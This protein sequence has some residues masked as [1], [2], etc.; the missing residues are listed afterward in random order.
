MTDPTR[1]RAADD[2]LV[3]VHPPEPGPSARLTSD[4]ATP[5]RGP[6]RQT[7][8]F[9]R[10]NKSALVGLVLIILVLLFSFLGPALY[11]TDQIHA[12]L[13]ATNLPPSSHHL[14]GTD[15]LGYDVLGRIMLGGQSSIEIGLAVALI[16]TTIGAIWGSLAA[17][18]GGIVDTLMMRV[19]DVLLA[20]PALFIVI[21]LATALHPNIWTLIGVISFISW[22][23]PARLIRGESLSIR[24]QA[25]VEAARR[26]GARQPWIL[27]RHIVPNAV[28]IIVVNATFQVADAVLLLAYLSFLG[29]G[30]PPPAAS[31][32]GILAEGLN[33][34]FNGYWWEIYPAGIIIVITVIAFNLL[35]DALRD[36]VDGRLRGR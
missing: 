17:L 28:G 12:N 6:L 16:A 7:G 20:V 30:L 22:L 3:I 31:W 19:V 9:L 15:D 13:T 18:T 4:H 32:G 21:F 10:R 27:R 1:P 25:F 5:A 33:N 29:F 35:G 2:A 24:T 11:R 23:V 36:L 34:M 8:R 26:F 14:L